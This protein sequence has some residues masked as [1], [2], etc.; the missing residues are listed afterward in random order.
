MQNLIHHSKHEN[1]RQQGDH[2]RSQ[3]QQQ[4]SPSNT[5]KRAVD[6]GR[7]FMIAIDFSE[8]STYAL[9]WTLD[10]VNFTDKDKLTL[11]SV[12]EPPAHSERPSFRNEFDTVEEEQRAMHNLKRLWEVVDGKSGH[13][14]RKINFKLS[15]RVEFDKPMEKL[16]EL[17]QSEQLA[18]VRCSVRH[19]S[20][21]LIIIV[22]QLIMGSHG[23][24]GK[25]ELGSVSNYCL[26]NS[27]VPVLVV[28]EPAQR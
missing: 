25:R 4:Q 16:V 8:C 18:M 27:R 28:R 23:K 9:E 1:D 21:V 15:L 20:F 19:I 6:T 13:L 7:H 14:Q 10:S 3:Q 5:H 17:S 2:D 24:T 12:I 26:K 11:L 22:V